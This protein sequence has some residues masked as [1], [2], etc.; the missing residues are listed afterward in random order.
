MYIRRCNGGSVNPGSTGSRPM[1]PQTPTHAQSIAY[2]FWRERTPA[3]CAGIF[4]SLSWRVPHFV[5][6]GIWYLRASRSAPGRGTISTLC[7]FGSSWYWGGQRFP[8]CLPSYMVQ[9]LIN[10][11]HKNGC[12]IVS[13]WSVP[14]FGKH[15]YVPIPGVWIECI[16]TR[17][18]MYDSCVDLNWLYYHLSLLGLIF[19]ID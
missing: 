10:G 8:C 13:D 4:H 2:A 7:S 1:G 3:G 17:G 9:P 11:P 16:L 6:A 14:I 15:R 5:S 18:C 19:T 12:T